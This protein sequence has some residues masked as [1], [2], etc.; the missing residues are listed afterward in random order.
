MLEFCTE[1]EK[2]CMP[3]DIIECVLYLHRDQMTTCA[4]HTLA[5]GRSL[6]VAGLSF[7]GLVNVFGMQSI[8]LSDVIDQEFFILL[9]ILKKKSANLFVFTHIL[10]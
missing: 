10:S 7:V 6:R 9:A 4:N 5:C 8:T 3:L 2:S 1:F